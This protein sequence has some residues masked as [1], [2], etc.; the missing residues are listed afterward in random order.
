MSKR[1]EK[2]DSITLGELRKLTAGWPDSTVIGFQG[3]LIPTPSM[4][5]AQMRRPSMTMYG[6]LYNRFKD[7]WEGPIQTIGST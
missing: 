3:K 6:T 4:C 2:I 7:Q 1:K 5:V